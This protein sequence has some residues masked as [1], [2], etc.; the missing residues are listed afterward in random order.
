[1][2][3]VDGGQEAGRAGRG[4][5]HEGGGTHSTAIGRPLGPADPWRE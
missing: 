3:G 2:H 4:D 1:V 5:V